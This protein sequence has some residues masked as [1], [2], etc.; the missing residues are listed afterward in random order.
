MLVDLTLKIVADILKK[1]DIRHLEL[2][3]ALNPVYIEYDD[4]SLEAKEDQ[5]IPDE[6]DIILHGDHNHA[7]IQV[8]DELLSDY[9]YVEM[10]FRHGQLEIFQRDREK[11]EV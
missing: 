4:E 11:E 10:R 8:I 9:S 1:T 2:T 3:D 6:Y 7:T 5:E